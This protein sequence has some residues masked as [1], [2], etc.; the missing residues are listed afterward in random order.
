VLYLNKN[1]SAGLGS[2]LNLCGRPSMSATRTT[3]LGEQMDGH[4]LGEQGGDQ[5]GQASNWSVL[6][7]PIASSASRVASRA[8]SKLAV[9]W[10]ANRPRLAAP[11]TA[12]ATAPAS[13]VG[14]S[15]PAAAPTL[16]RLVLAAAVAG[17][18]WYLASFV[19]HVIRL[20]AIAVVL[21][22]LLVRR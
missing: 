22:V 4:L 13:P 18:V 5:A 19:G 9:W 10:E 14:T 16:A 20:A 2:V 21:Y 12:P 7:V 3:Q 1:V 8:A 6:D 11:A 17:A 15:T